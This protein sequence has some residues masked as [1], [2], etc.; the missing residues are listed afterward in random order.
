MS[1]IVAVVAEARG[2]KVKKPSLEAVSAACELAG[3]C[4]GEVVVLVAGAGLGPATTEL[5]RAGAARVVALESPVL[6]SYS[7][8]GYCAVLVEALE[9]LAPAAVLM[10][11]TAM[12][13]DLMPRIS[14]ALGTGLVSDVTALHFDDGRF[15]ATKPVFAGKAYQK[16]Y[17]E[18]TP[19]MATLRP[20]NFEARA[21]GGGAAVETR[22]P[23]LTQEMLKAI[24]ADVV[25]ASSGSV[26]LSEAKVVVAGGRGLKGP[27]H[28]HLLEELAQAFG[29][30]VAAVG[31][32]RAIVDAGWRPHD[33][34]VG[35]TGKTVAPTLYI[36]A[37][38]SGAIQHIAGMRTARYIVAINKDKDAPIFK[39]ADYGI[40]GDV[41]EVLPA[42]TAAVK[43]AL[44]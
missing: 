16:S 13:K 29:P 28:W 24:V 6:A 44:A 26:P 35:Q 27:E 18:R 1:K 31:A 41:F 37:G 42:L 34:Q 3:K 39:V 25:S 21:G 36:A 8:D 4:G 19:F 12:G 30:G 2:G 40:V 14:A 15:G 10:P 22:A 20:N 23:A 32:T 9:P 17:M 38:L 11:H 5:A 7:G 43:Q 33:E